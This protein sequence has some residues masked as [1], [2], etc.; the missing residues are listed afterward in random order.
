MAKFSFDETVEKLSATPKGKEASMYGPI[1]D[2]FIHV[3]GYPAGDVDID[4]TGEGG[5]PDVTARAPSGFLDAKGDSPKIDWIVVEAKD[6]RG[7]FVDS[8]S[9]ELIFEKKSKY[10]GPH[11]AWFVM[12]EP[13]VWVLRPVAGAALSADA[14]VKVHIEKGG[15][16]TFRKQLEA[17]MADKAGVSQQLSKFRDGD[18]S[19]VASEKLAVP[20]ANP[21][22]SKQTLTRIALNRKRFF[23]EIRDATTHLQS[24]VAGELARLADQNRLD[25]RSLCA[26]RR[27]HF[28][29]VP[30]EEATD[31]LQKAQPPWRLGSSNQRS[32]AFRRYKTTGEARHKA[33]CG[34]PPVPFPGTGR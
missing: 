10:V 28:F 24:A 19:M 22:P 23:Q 2:I 14:D 5:R 27:I 32:Q 12:A 15:E 21:P 17:L 16:A 30:Q 31:Y 11:T 1:R 18:V 8:V 4:V 7:C 26:R 29:V 3:L 34:S 6:E 13:T 20:A 25:A 9:R 33:S